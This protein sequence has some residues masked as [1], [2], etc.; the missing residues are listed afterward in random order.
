MVLREAITI[1]HGRLIMA[2]FAAILN[3][4]WSFRPSRR[5]EA[6]S[7]PLASCRCR[8][9]LESLEDRTMPSLAAPILSG[10][11]AVQNTRPTFSWIPVVG[12]AS[13]DL[14][15]DDATTGQSQVVGAKTTVP[16]FTLSD[17]AA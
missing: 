15:V 11:T 10:S 5:Q 3:T 17:K 16:M 9:A 6:A 12:A 14:W 4:L 13:Y 7:L 8:P 2:R 1:E